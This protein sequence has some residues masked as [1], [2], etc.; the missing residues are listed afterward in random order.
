M[1]HVSLIISLAA[2]SVLGTTMVSAATKHPPRHAHHA[3]MP[4][5]VERAANPRSSMEPARMIEVISPAGFE[6]FFSELADLAAVGPP[7]LE[8]MSGLAAAYGLSF[9][10]PDWLPDV[11]ARFALTMPGA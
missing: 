11:V 3:R 1:K 4:V 2:A 5:N 9:G 8:A 7:T 10:N 6:G